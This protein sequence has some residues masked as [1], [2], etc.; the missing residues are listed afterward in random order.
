[1]HVNELPFELLIQI[2]THTIDD[3]P[4]I[5]ITQSPLILL[6]TCRLWRF[7]A[8]SVSSLWSS[9]QIRVASQTDSR[10]LGVLDRWLKLSRLHPL[11]ISVVYLPPTDSFAR[12]FNA[13]S[14]D[15]VER[16]SREATRWRHVRFA[17]P[18]ATVTPLFVA[19][20][21]GTCRVGDLHS[22]D[23]D[24]Q[25]VWCPRSCQ[26]SAR[27]ILHTIRLEKLTEL[28][29]SLDLAGLY[30][31]DDVY[32]LFSRAGN[33]IKCK[34]G[35]KLNSRSVLSISERQLVMARLKTLAF[36]FHYTDVLSDPSM[37]SPSL[38]SILDV[39]SAPSLE[40]FQ[41]EWP[42]CGPSSYIDDGIAHSLVSFLA[43]AG[44]TLE[45]L[46][47]HYLPI[48]SSQ[49]FDVLSCV[50]S[51]AQL[52]IRM[53]ILNSVTSEALAFLYSS[54]VEGQVPLP[55]LRSLVIHDPCHPCPVSAVVHLVESRRLENF[56]FL[57]TK[58]VHDQLDSHTAR[59][60][61]KGMNVDIDH[62]LI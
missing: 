18:S 61:E 32:S 56:T 15:V 26:V 13:T 34:L 14:V 45:R 31:V 36:S 9:F 21:D 44:S 5:D 62:L 53:C 6:R 35:V 30:T 37:P 1:M 43:R 40:E 46:H 52:D 57:T 7:L 24:M 16:L 59:W 29:C 17:V 58:V 12:R 27:N 51:V 50:P 20:A 22:L 42:T 23:L 60:R 8:L 55:R 2:F 3:D 4:S 47:L 41:V 25:G 39:L 54:S 38:R 11:D 19:L 49:L 48:S 33:L 10:I 28:S